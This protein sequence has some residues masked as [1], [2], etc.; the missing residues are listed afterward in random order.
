[1]P[2]KKL[3]QAQIIDKEQIVGRDTISMESLHKCLIFFLFFYFS[4]F[5]L[6]Y[7]VINAIFINQT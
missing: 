6:V 2:R 4:V 5:K 3:C 1:M 7:N